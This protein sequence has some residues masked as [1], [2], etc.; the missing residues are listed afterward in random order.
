V[1]LPNEEIIETVHSRLSQFPDIIIWSGRLIKE[2]EIPRWMASGHYQSIHVFIPLCLTEFRNRAAGK[3]HLLIAVASV[4]A[5]LAPT[6]IKSCE[7][8]AALT[9]MSEVVGPVVTHCF[10]IVLACR[11]CNVNIGASTTISA[12]TIIWATRSGL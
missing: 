4:I 1:V 12:A 9:H 5:I 10:V 6:A 2:N 11:C 3:D 7:V 8:I